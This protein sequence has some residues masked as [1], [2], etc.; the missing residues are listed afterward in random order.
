[1][2]FKSP[3]SYIKTRF[4]Y[5]KKIKL[6]N[7]CKRIYLDN[8]KKCDY[9]LINLKDFNSS[10]VINKTLY[11]VIINNDCK[12][13]EMLTYLKIREIIGNL[14]PNAF[15]LHNIRVPKKING[16]QKIEEIDILICAVKENIGVKKAIVIECK[17]KEKLDN[18]DINQL[19]E[20][21]DLIRQIRNDI[22][23]NGFI[24]YLGNTDD[25]SNAVNVFD[26][27]KIRNKI[28]KFIL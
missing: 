19:S 22:R 14:I 2:H 18:G 26:E 11:D 6:C 21:I 27:K 20:H 16:T 13:F 12:I 25:K 23:V 9:C 4:Q 17:M 5:S 15:I 7:G 24:I 10:F 8:R 1:M 3:N 28:I